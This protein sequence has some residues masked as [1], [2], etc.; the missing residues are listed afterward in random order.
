MKKNALL[1]LLLVL[2][3]TIN[4]QELGKISIKHAGNSGKDFL[5]K[6]PS[7]KIFIQDFFINYQ[8][9]FDHTEIAQGG[10]ELG[11]GYR[12]DAKTRLVLAVKGVSP[13]TLQAITDALYQDY[14]KK[15]ESKGFEIVTAKDIKTK[16]FDGF[17]I[18]QGGTPTAG[19]AGFIRTAPTGF[20]YF[21]EKE[22]RSVFDTGLKLSKELE[23]MT[24]AR[25]KAALAF[26]KD[27]ESMISKGLTK[28]LGG[29][30]KIKVATELSLLS[31]RS[32]SL[33]GYREK[34]SNQGYFNS[35]LT[36]PLVV[37]GVFSDKKYKA[38]AS[39]QT[40]N[41]GSSNGAFTVFHADDTYKKYSQPVECDEAKYKKG[42]DMALR[43]L[44][45]SSVDEFVKKIK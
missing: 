27:V 30:A 25:V 37:S 35:K 17:D 4:G 9:I 31:G 45:M 2:G 7:K 19:K 36:K 40:D 20:S 18:V 38:T 44:I 5:K 28:S 6:A 39:A 24:I 16:W 13:E 11:G 21:T 12:G 34:M 43:A 26:T 1:C 32:V 8:M 29:V 41:W 10:R 3:F 22:S 23:G 15:L 42:A 14:V 33:L